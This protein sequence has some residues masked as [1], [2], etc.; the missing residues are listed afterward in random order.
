M[1]MCLTARLYS[2]YDFG[3]ASSR[4]F[5]S[6]S[7]SSAMSLGSIRES[8]ILGLQ[9]LVREATTESKLL[10]WKAYHPAV[11]RLVPGAASARSRGQSNTATSR[12]LQREAMPHVYQSNAGAT[13]SV[14]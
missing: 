10:F 1:G 9:L 3:V 4:R 5:S 7:E 6:R 14:G 11:E 2:S 12:I 13:R 8:A